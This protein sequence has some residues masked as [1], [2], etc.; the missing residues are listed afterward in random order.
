MDSTYYSFRPSGSSF[1]NPCQKA[2]LNR[3]PVCNFS[4]WRSNVLFCHLRA[5]AF[6][7]AYMHVYTRTHPHTHIF[8]Y[9]FLQTIRIMILEHHFLPEYV[10]YL[11]K[12][13]S[14]RYVLPAFLWDVVFCSYKQ[15]C[16]FILAS[17]FPECWVDH[18]GIWPQGM[19]QY[20]QSE[21][22]PDSGL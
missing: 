18:S 22:S 6:M 3:L 2:L 11:G 12:S 1:H 14:E 10:K 13:P 9:F 17:V 21:L 19:L 4:A 8:T 7:S 5:L 15:Q 16:Q 20:Y